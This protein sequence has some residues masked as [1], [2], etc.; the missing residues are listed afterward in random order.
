MSECYF[1]CFVLELGWVSAYWLF[2]E[3][4]IIQINHLHSVTAKLLLQLEPQGRKKSLQ[5]GPPSPSSNY[6]LVSLSLYTVE[7]SQRKGRE[8]ALSKKAGSMVNPKWVLCL[9]RK[10]KWNQWFTGIIRHRTTKN[11]WKING[12]G[13]IYSIIQEVLLNI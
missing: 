9:L 2:F 11:P 8:N 3:V 13:S 7:S 6:G 12:M 4:T 10:G 1:W 5:A